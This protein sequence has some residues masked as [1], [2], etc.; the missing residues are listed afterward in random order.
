[1][2]ADALDLLVCPACGS[3]LDLE[4]RTVLCQR[5]HSFDV[6]RQGYVSLLAGAATKLT[7]DSADMIT[8]RGEFL[9]A[10]HFDPIAT[11][12]AAAVGDSADLRI[13]EIG[14]G[15]GHYL[16]RAV[17]VAEDAIGL[18]VDISKAA[19]RRTARAHPRVASIVADAWQNLPV[20][21]GSCTHALSIF[22]PR[23]PDEIRRILC[24]DGSFVVVTPTQ[25][26]L[27]ELIEPLGMVRVDDDK[28]R[29]LGESMAGRFDRVDRHAVDFTMELDGSAIAAV[30][31]MGP[32]ARHLSAEQRSERIATLP[33]PT[34][35][36][37]SVV[38]ATY[39]PRVAMTSA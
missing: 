15:T 39:R 9:D 13:L 24:A 36:T 37:A 28:T 3:D 4:E 12:V 32:T 34:T 7:G 8:A 18:G 38:V 17:D 10:G 1:M 29:R 11:A 5:G 19:A 35:V 33:M 16:S 26:H 23:N 6:A 20:R 27:G 22:S 31:G 25:R 21:T 30:V 2:L 14:A